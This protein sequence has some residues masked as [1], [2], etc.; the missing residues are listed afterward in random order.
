MSNYEK[1]KQI[2]KDRLD[3]LGCGSDQD[4]KNEDRQ[5]EHQQKIRDFAKGLDK[6][7]EIK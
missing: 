2:V 5:R 1:I 7:T 4:K 6:Y 3:E